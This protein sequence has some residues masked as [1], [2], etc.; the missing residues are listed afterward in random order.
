M[1]ISVICPAWQ[2]AATIAETMAS[3]QGQTIKAHKTHELIVVDD[4]STDQT[5]EI[6]NACGARVIQ[7]QHAGAPVALNAG[8]AAATGELLA[9]ID[10]DDLWTPD[11]LE[12]Q[13]HTMKID[14]SL[15]AV[16]GLAEDFVCPT[17]DAAFARRIRIREK[18]YPGWYTGT[19]LVKAGVFA[20]VGKFAQSMK[21]GFSIDWIDR[22]RMGGVKILMMEEL[23]LRRRI[24]PGSL[25]HRTPQRDAGYVAMARQAILRRRNSEEGH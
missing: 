25:S 9:F 3:V 7:R 18:P 12:K 2:A 17:A 16:L 8:V 10:A 1:K 4:G 14:S 19:M 11:K 23:V 15:D 21:V 20:R 6:A 5:A 24:H 13:M 22:A